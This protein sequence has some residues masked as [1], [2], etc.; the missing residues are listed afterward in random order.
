MSRIGC[1]RRGMPSGSS[2]SSS[3][4]SAFAEGIYDVRRRVLSSSSDVVYGGAAMASSSSSSNT[5]TDYAKQAF[6]N[7]LIKHAGEQL[8]YSRPKTIALSGPA[9]FLGSNV[10]DAILD[11][12]E[13]RRANGLD[14]GDKVPGWRL[15]SDPSDWIH[16]CS[17]TNQGIRRCHRRDQKSLR[18]HPRRNLQ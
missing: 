9:G 7:P 4:S 15:N 10:V 3:C 6:N 16:M 14:P 17:R 5:T 13:F 1:F 12:H 8:L 18:C 2:C 11:A